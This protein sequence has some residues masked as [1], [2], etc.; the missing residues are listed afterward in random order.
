MGSVVGSVR[1]SVGGVSRGSVF[2]RNPCETI[3]VR[4]CVVFCRT[5]TIDETD[6][7]KMNRSI[8]AN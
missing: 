6:D 1:G 5:C 7:L 2:C 4:C 8:D 3:V